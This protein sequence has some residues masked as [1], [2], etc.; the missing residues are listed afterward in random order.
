MISYKHIYISKQ[1]LKVVDANGLLL[2]YTEYPTMA[3]CISHRHDQTNA[4]L[5]GLFSS[6]E[7]CVMFKCHDHGAMCDLFFA[8]CRQDQNY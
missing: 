8:H 6:K 4:C 3:V 2:I 1:G 7:S 5:L